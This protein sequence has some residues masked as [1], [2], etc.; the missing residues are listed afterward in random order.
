MI[1][2][3]LLVSPTFLKSSQGRRPRCL[4]WSEVTSR[5]GDVIRVKSAPLHSGKFLDCGGREIDFVGEVDN[6]ACLLCYSI[7]FVV[8]VTAIRWVVVGMGVRD[9][10]RDLKLR[11]VIVAVGAKE[12]VEIQIGCLCTRFMREK[13]GNQVIVVAQIRQEIGLV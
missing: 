5:V 6:T 12:A 11:R 3:N 1:V 10:G 7:K 9:R 13:F 8:V 2:N 4:R